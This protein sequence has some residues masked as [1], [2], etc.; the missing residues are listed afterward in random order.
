[1]KGTAGFQARRSSTP[2]HHHNIGSCTSNGIDSEQVPGIFSVLTISSGSPQTSAQREKR[3]LTPFSCLIACLL[4]IPCLPGISQ[5]QVPPPPT[6]ITSSGLSTEVTTNGN[7]H[8]IT[9]GTRPGGASGTNLFHSFG[10]FG[11][12]ANNI[13][14]FLNAG[15]FDL[16][17]IPLADGLPTSNIL[18]RVTGGNISNVFGTI[19]TTGFGN[20]NLFLMNPTGFLFGPNATVNVAGMVAFTTADYLKLTD[21]ARFNTIPNAAADA[22]LTALPV[23][24]FGFLGSNPGAITVQGSQ[25]SVT[26]GQSISLVG[27]NISIESGTPEGGTTKPARLSAPNGTIQLASAA[28]PGEFEATTLQ[29]LPNVDG[30]SFTSFGSISLAAGSTVDVSGTN[31]VSIRG[32]QFIL[33]VNDAVLTTAETPGGPGSIT[34]ARGSSVITSNAGTEPGADVEITTGALQM[35]AALV[36]SRTTGEG[37]SGALSITAQS[38]DLTNGSQIASIAEGS[39][40][41]GAITIATAESFTASGFDA[42]GTVPGIPFIY[43]VSPDTGLPLVTSGIFTTTSGDGPGG[44]ITMNA[45]DVSLNN[46]GTLASIVTGNGR[47][48]DI[49][50]NVRNLTVQN[51]GL[52]LSAAGADFTTFE[53]RGS[54][55]GG[56]INVTAED[57]IR[58]SGFN[59]DLFAISFMWSASFN[60]G[61]GGTIALSARNISVDQGGMVQSTSDGIAKAGD[62]GLTSLE[63]LAV[64][65]FDPMAGTQSQIFSSAAGEGTSGTISVTARSVEVSDS[66]MILTIGNRGNISVQASQDISVTGGGL[67][68]AVGG[69]ESPGDITLTADLVLISG[70]RSR[71]ENINGGGEEGK[72]GNI[73][74]Q[75]REVIVTDDARINSE[76]T[77]GDGNILIA[78]TESATVSD[79]AKVRMTNESGPGGLVQIA[80]PFITLDQGIIQ[81]LTI[82]VGDAGSIMLQGKTIALNGSQINSQ[83]EQIIGRGG[84]VTITASDRLS[85][86]GQFAGSSTDPP[87]PAGIFSR[88]FTFGGDAGKIAITA[89]AMEMSGGTRIDSSTSSLGSEPLPP[90][91][92]EPTT[93]NGGPISITIAD[94]MSL[95]GQ[96]TGLYSETSGTWNGGA[97]NVHANEVQLSNGAVISAESTGSGAAGSVTIQGNSPAQS[98]LIDG[99]GSGIFTDT[100]GTGAGGNIF[101]NAD[102]VTLQNGGTLSAS[103]SGTA[104]TATGGSITLNATDQVIMTDGA[105]IT[106][107]ST[108]PGNAGNVTISGDSLT[109]ASGG[110]I[111]A[112]TSGVGNGGSIAI[113]TTDDVTVSGV[114]TDGQTRSGIFAKTQTSGGSGSG[115]GGGGGGSGGGSGGGGA[116][117]KPGSAGDITITANNLLLDG[118]AQ[119]DS[120][121]TSGGAGGTVSIT[122]AENITIAGSSTRLTSDATRGNGKGGN[123]TLVA[124]NIT[125]RDGAS[126]TAATGGKG[127]AGNVTLTAL[128]QLL[129][130]SAGTVTTSTSG[131]GKGGTITI[132]AGQVLLDGQGTGITAD[133]LRPF[134]DMTITINILHQNVGDLVVQLDSPTGTRLALL[135]R[136]GGN[137]DNFTGT[138]F[139]DQATTQITSGSAPF[140]GTFTAREPLGQLNNELVAGNWTLNVR[141]QATGNP[142]SLESWTLQIGAETFQSTSGSLMIPDNGNVRSTITVANPTVPTVQ[143]VGE[144]TGIG[145]NVTINAGTVTVQ[146]GATMSATTRGSGQGGT[147]TVN[148]TGAVALTGPGSGLFTDTQGTGA[149]GNIFVDADSVTLQNS[150]TLSADTSGAGH[151][152]TIDIVATENLSLID[153]SSISTNSNSELENAGNAGVIRLSAPVID[154]QTALVSASTVGPGDAG[155]IV[156]EANRVILGASETGRLHEQGADIFTRTTGPGL[157]GNITIRGRSGPESQ[158]EIV[159]ISGSS[160]MNSESFFGRSDVQ[161]NAGNISIQTNKLTLSESRLTTA[162]ESSTGNAGD[163]TIVASDEVR[164]SSHGQLS[165]G[166]IE[167]ASGN[168]GR[169]AVSAPS[170]I[171][172]SDGLIS[173]NTDYLGNAG[174]I[175]IKA[176]SVQVKT[177]GQISSSSVINQGAPD[178]IP[179]GSAG[180]ITVQG[181]TSPAQS[182]LIDGAGSG[183]FTDTQGTGAGGNIFVNADSVTLT[184]G[185][186]VSASSTGQ[187]ENPGAAGSI[188]I[189]ATNGLTMQNSTIT[190][191]AGQGAGGGDIK[192]TTAP[193]ATVWLQNSTMSASV[194]D[195]PGG[196][197]NIEID[198]QYVI[199]QNSQILATVPQGQGGTITIT[200]NLFL[201]DATSIVSADSGSGLHGTVT[202]QS[203]NAPASGKIQP[204]GKS[205]LLATSLLNQRCA[206]LAGGEFSSFTV[207]GRDNLPTE[208][209]SWLASPLYAAGVGHEGKAEG[210]KAEGERPD[211]PILSLRQ[212]APA[213]FLTQAFAVDWSA[214]CQS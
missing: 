138:Q 210:G 133:T 116:A 199:L 207:A 180:I 45:G 171:L 164:I 168:G 120:S 47:G 2:D 27:G 29:P 159:T 162:S 151:G 156:L 211:A 95:S 192:V 142:G 76:G 97:I 212:I 105:S 92:T 104:S 69:P 150:G 90:I 93:G 5:A 135:S 206:A 67:I 158:A 103:T 91:T 34:L 10:D 179:S 46:V 89:G 152:G 173:T 170:I 145:G 39:G 160:R 4:L 11:V 101:V 154:V 81:T 37:A 56:D 19:Q 75:A 203:P 163:I 66:A 26:D 148:A 110:R 131:S 144:P 195:G 63:R 172:E 53:L 204:L 208:P 98:V 102:S 185:A 62:I 157:A 1:M 141:D 54:G 132:Q 209:G 64:S 129:L 83:T 136:V 127:D 167:F 214:G 117:P 82:G 130:Q 51:G 33:T 187:I 202:I 153:A 74:L 30:T 99:S 40:A 41:G 174:E 193:S 134:A 106:A 72:T 31:T 194:A 77:G 169:I 61:D 20:A 50:L 35:D 121:T 128:D 165:S 6:P 123:I 58:V 65:G 166:A 22:L 177:G 44:Q 59:P 140:T 184:N 16:N 182:V 190:T 108:G 155:N 88:T 196:G 122:T 60:T 18:G 87:G 111:E 107:S 80:A 79:G 9:G 119:I 42:E 137:G 114:S 175:E 205:P 213:G 57:S 48:G 198:P 43:Y 188:D 7:I 125:V 181:L 49:T 71:I 118:G 36:T 113:T 23:A 94:T 32:G 176:N 126:V 3:F 161:G 55:R 139:N 112:S 52:L 15:S 28:S 25:F 200:A 8:D 21:N 147:L 13:A 14:N 38:I 183:V 109:I 146:N 100:Q 149:G 70:S 12:P 143:G 84:D 17:G 85:I 197:G 96:G 178:F 86:T 24:S 73:A 201:P 189:T 191:E 78:A 68:A 186:T 115:S 124:K